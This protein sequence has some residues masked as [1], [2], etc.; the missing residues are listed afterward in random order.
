MWVGDVVA[1]RFVIERPVASGGMGSVFYA[2]DLV[3]GRPV[4][5]KVMDHAHEAARERFHREA[6]VLSELAHPCLVRYVAHGE[7]ASGEPYLAMEWLEGEDLSRRLEAGPLP[8]AE[9][10]ALVRRIA[11]GLAQAHARGVVH[12][13]V[14]PSNV[15]LIAGEARQ[16]VLLDFGIAR[17]IQTKAWT[18]TG[19]V[20]GTVGY[21][22]P[23][24]ARGEGD[25]DPRADVFG[26]GCV[27]FECL[28]GEPAFSG[29]HE[30]AVLAKLL[31][32]E[33]P[34]LAEHRPDL[35]A[36]LDALLGAMLAQNPTVR[37]RDAAA[38]R[39]A[40]DALISTTEVAGVTENIARHP[41]SRVPYTRGITGSEKAIRSVLCA[42]PWPVDPTGS[43]TASEVILAGREA[44]DHLARKFNAEMTWLPANR[45]IF[46]FRRAESAGDLATL[47]AACGAELRARFPEA[48]VAVAT[49]VADTGSEVMI[50]PVIDR[51]ALLLARASPGAI[52]LDDVTAGLL[53]S[54]FI[55]ANRDGVR[56]LERTVA[57]DDE[58]RPLMG[59][60]TPFVGRERELA[61]LDALL[62]TCLADSVSG[63][64]VV[65]GE[66]GMGKTRLRQEFVARAKKR[67]P[68]LTILSSRG[69]I[70]TAGSS[71]GVVRQVVRSAFGFVEGEVHRDDS[72]RIRTGVGRVFREAAAEDARRVGDFLGELVGVRHPE[73]P[74]IPLQAARESAT[75]M[76]QWLRQSFVEWLGALASAGAVLVV[77]DDFH[78]ADGTS[79][80]WIDEALRAYAEVPLGVLALGRPDVREKGTRFTSQQEVQLESLRRRAATELVRAVLPD[81]QAADA[82]RLI[83]QAQGNA[84]YLEEL[85]RHAASGATD[86]PSTI[87]AMTQTRL[88]RLDPDARSLL[89]AASVFGEQFWTNGVEAILGR[90]TDA[91]RWLELLCADEFVTKSPISRFSEHDEYRFRHSL[92]REAAYASLTDDDRRRAHVHAAHWL[93][94]AGE[95]DAS[96]MVE[97]YERGNAAREA[98]KW[99]LAAIE[100]AMSAAN[101]EEAFELSSRGVA[102]AAGEQRTELLALQ[103]FNLQSLMRPKSAVPPALEVLRSSAPGSRSWGLGM[104]ALTLACTLLGDATTA[105]P[106]VVRWV[107]LPQEPD[108][109][110]DVARLMRGAHW[111]ARSMGHKDLVAQIMSRIDHIATHGDEAPLIGVWVH[112]ARA[113]EAFFSARWFP[114]GVVEA[115]HA[116]NLARMIGQIPGAQI[117]GQIAVRNALHLGDRE[118]VDRELSTGFGLPA[119]S[120]F[121]DVYRLIRALLDGDLPAAEKAAA[122]AIATRTGTHE[123]QAP[124][125]LAIGYSDAGRPDDAER[126]VA[127]IPESLS[128]ALLAHRA[129]V[130][131]AR[132]RIALARHAPDAAI[133]QCDEGDAAAEEWGA[134]IPTRHFIALSRAEALRLLGKDDDAHRTLRALLAEIDDLAARMDETTRSNYLGRGFPCARIRAVAREWGLLDET[135]PVASER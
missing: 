111:Y 20:L 41:A 3:E 63:A 34:R 56:V 35:G 24:Q 79:V 113:T 61:M 71:L 104:E 15:F 88:E 68:G 118:F 123:I 107:E 84:Y 26:L 92:V 94:T 73:P 85:V 114:F 96:L 12:R 106:Y 90:G 95:T 33:A 78:W 77:I 110:Q 11:D 14:K 83:E 86:L 29:S 16:A 40:L 54:R 2:T 133:T 39:D 100:S 45:A 97:H 135:G 31:A 125:L 80:A 23:E 21:M 6:R 130:H 87:V 50:G 67:H 76:S 91:K 17:V 22:A 38:V 58:P 7:T 129:D 117:A 126:L 105:R 82:A 55:L 98:V 44:L 131:L 65:I 102:V 74:T 70:V 5:V 27:L 120:R 19:T 42:E 1:E 127:G 132:A 43:T 115:D 8:P 89:R 18:R 122:R 4:A 10:T 75:V 46:A 72:A 81:A 128:S 59:R 109:S 69:E 30:V 52:V 134:F 124:A 25:T 49:G 48:R 62:D 99:Y 108:P 9:A 66:A 28:T 36:E 13:D 32:G 60:R 116:R 103:A 93:E 37:P 57:L 64:A 112:L 119:V 51:V 121:L 47:A 53:P 101:F